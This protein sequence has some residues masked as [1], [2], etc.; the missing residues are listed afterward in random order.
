MA[1]LMVYAEYLVFL[2]QSFL[3][4]PPRKWHSRHSFFG[5]QHFLALYPLPL[6]L[7]H[8]IALEFGFFDPN[9]LIWVS[10]TPCGSFTS[11]LLLKHFLALGLLVGSPA[12]PW[13]KRV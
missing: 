6:Q 10:S 4:E 13:E 5:F 7:Q 9:A 1:E 3:Y 8:F 2:Q 11:I 12:E